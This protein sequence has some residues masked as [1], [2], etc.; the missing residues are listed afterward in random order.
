[1]DV[2]TIEAHL[3]MGAV[4][5]GALGMGPSDQIGLGITHVNLSDESGLTEDE[6]TLEL[7][8]R[9]TRGSNLTIKPDLQYV[10]NPGGDANVD[11]AFVATLRLEWSF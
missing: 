1:P 8:W 10:K 3:G 11:N 7:Y 5:N 6:T 9:T 2:N 4:W